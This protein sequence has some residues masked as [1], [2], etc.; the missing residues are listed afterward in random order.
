MGSISSL[1]GVI[2][3]LVGVAWS[4]CVFFVYFVNMLR[5]GIVGKIL[6]LNVKRPTFLDIFC[7]LR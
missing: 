7:M 6:N 5:G 3:V 2:F 1:Q 4:L